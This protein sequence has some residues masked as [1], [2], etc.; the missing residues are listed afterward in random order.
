MHVK[1]AHFDCPWTESEDASMLKGVY[2]Y[3]TG[4]WEAIH[5]DPALNLSQVMTLSIVILFFVMNQ[6]LYVQYWNASLIGDWFALTDSDPT[7]L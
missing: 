3:G 1:D 2:K 6:Y 5:I 4:N 7:V